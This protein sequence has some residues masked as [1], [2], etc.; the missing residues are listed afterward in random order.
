MGSGRDTEWL[1]KFFDGVS[2]AWPT[3][4]SSAIKINWLFAKRYNEM[5]FEVTEVLKIEV[6]SSDVR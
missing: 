1:Q 6:D 5:D 3:P 4:R 2:L